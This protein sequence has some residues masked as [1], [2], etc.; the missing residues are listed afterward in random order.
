MR[1]AARS[2][3][4]FGRTDP[5]WAIL[6]HPDKRGGRW[7]VGEFL[8]TGRADAERVWALVARWRD[9]ASVRRALD[10]GCGVGRVSFALAAQVGSVVGVDVAPSMIARARQLDPT[11]GRCTFQLN[12]TPDLRAFATGSFDLVHSVLTLQHLPPRTAL[13]YVA[14]FGRVLEDGGIAVFQLPTGPRRGNRFGDKPLLRHVGP[15]VSV[16]RRTT[17]RLVCHTLLRRPWM[18]MYGVPT[19]TVARTLAGAGCE[20]LEVVEDDAAGPAWHSCTYVARRTS[21]ADP[22]PAAVPTP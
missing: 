1:R 19:R 3:E 8:A 16:I 5:L 2:W 14:E 21:S 12:T 18:D 4:S 11:D 22:A 17:G 9:P 13:R 7:D 15:A 6:T 20:L 10:F